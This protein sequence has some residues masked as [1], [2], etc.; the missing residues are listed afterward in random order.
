MASR[1]DNSADPPRNETEAEEA[2][3]HTVRRRR[4]RRGRRGGRSHRSDAPSASAQNPATRS[5]P[6]KQEPVAGAVSLAK[7]ADA[8]NGQ[9]AGASNGN[10]GKGPAVNGTAENTDRRTGVEEPP[11]PK[12]SM[13]RRIDELGDIG[14]V[15]FRDKSSPCSRFI[16]KEAFD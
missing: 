10:P 9:G 16:L 11:T 14:V 8:E 4:R 15:A 12:P 13:P 6:P 1:D 5:D 7:E 2:R 3:P